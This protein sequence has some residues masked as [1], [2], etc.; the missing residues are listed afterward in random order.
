MAQPLV[1]PREHSAEQPMR[2]R[3]I[4]VEMRQQ[5]RDMMCDAAILR[6][7]TVDQRQRGV[8]RRVVQRL[9]PL[10]HLRDGRKARRDRKLPRQPQR[11]RVNR[12]HPQP[13]GICGQLPAEL[14]VARC[15]LMRKLRVRP[16]CGFCD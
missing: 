3:P 15:D 13:R 12:L 2:T 11:Q 1:A 9:G 10:R 16:W 7:R 5:P 4:V 6:F 8:G 14:A